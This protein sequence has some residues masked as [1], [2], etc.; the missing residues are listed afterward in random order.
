[1][2]GIGIIFYRKQKHADDFMLGSR[3]I[4]Y[5]VTAIAT[6]ASDMSTWLFMA[7]PGLVYREGLSAI[8]VAVGLL[9]GM[10]ATWTYIAP[11]LRLATEHH[12]TPTLASFFEAHF[13]DSNGTI[14]LL[15]AIITLV[16]FTFYISSGIVGLGRTIEIA[17]GINYHIGILFGTIIVS[18]Y[19]ILGGF[20]AVA[21][22]DFF[23]GMLVLLVILGVPIAA[24]L[25]TGGI[26]PTLSLIQQ[27]PLA[28]ALLP[29]S[30]LSAI[31]HIIISA[32]GWGLGYFGLPHILI[33]FMGI[34]NVNNMKKARNM[35]LTWQVISLGGALLI[36]LTGIAYFT[37]NPLTQSEFVF[38]LLAKT[39]FSP[40]LAGLVLCGILAAAIS[41]MDSQ[42]LVSAS[43]VAEDLYKKFINPH[44]TKEKLLSISRLGGFVITLISFLLAY[45][46][47]KNILDLVYYAWAGLGASF[48]PLMIASL[49]WPSL[50]K[51]GAIAGM[52]TGA[53]IAGIWPHLNTPLQSD[54]A[55]IP[56]FF[57][58]FLAMWI[59]TRL[60]QKK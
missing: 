31:S 36:G 59:T 52:I 3:S 32:F 27:K 24:C 43:T 51:E 38:I 40:F 42:I 8:W 22:N 15:S 7:F 48:G 41:T 33:N 5:W 46:N 23:Q 2:L 56:A 54:F 49:Y 37:S 34:D 45:N 55:L 21:W 57:M 11:K 30:S 60:T 29:D 18:L 26:Q 28:L 14:R 19:T 17:F 25:A 10:Y 1:M 9:L 50:T 58:S 12:N 53:I 44:V 39:L 35:G 16:F 6:Q 4:N 47:D 13:K 20:L